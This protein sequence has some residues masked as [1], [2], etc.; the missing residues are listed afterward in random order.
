M[1]R[2]KS[3]IFVSIAFGKDALLFYLLTKTST[4]GVGDFRITC[5]FFSFQ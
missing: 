2:V 5:L 1:L 4:I 3:L